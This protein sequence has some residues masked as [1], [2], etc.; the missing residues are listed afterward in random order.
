MFGSTLLSL[1]R[2]LVAFVCTNNPNATPICVP[3]LSINIVVVSVMNANA[4][5]ASTQVAK[6]EKAW[7]RVVLSVIARFCVT[8]SRAL[9]S[10]PSVVSLVVVV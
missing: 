10:L 7:A 6:V 2:D 9:P 8:I 4:N 1:H 3:T 5:D